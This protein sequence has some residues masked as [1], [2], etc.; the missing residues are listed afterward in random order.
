MTPIA[1]IIE[2]IKNAIEGIPNAFNGLFS[3]INLI[4]VNTTLN[5]CFNGFLEDVLIPIGYISFLGISKIFNLQTDD[6]NKI[7][8]DIPIPSVSKIGTSS[9]KES[10]PY[11]RKPLSASEILLVIKEFTSMV[12][13]LIPNFL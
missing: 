8:E 5:P 4:I 10:V 6:F 2:M 1:L 11:A 13:N 9:F 7:S 12:I 3:I